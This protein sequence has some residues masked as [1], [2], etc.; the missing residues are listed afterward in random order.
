[1]FL[2]VGWLGGREKAFGKSDSELRNVVSALLT[3]LFFS[4]L[5]LGLSA[6]GSGVGGSC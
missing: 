5:F 4:F 2:V 3:F 1:M 6:E